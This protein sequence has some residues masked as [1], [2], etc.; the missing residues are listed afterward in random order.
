MG[1]PINTGTEERLPGLS[2]DGKYLFF[3]WL[4]RYNNKDFDH[5]IFWVSTEIIEK[6]R[7]N[8]NEKK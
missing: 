6:L 1:E 5:D 8:S 3:T 7:G 2:P 4:T